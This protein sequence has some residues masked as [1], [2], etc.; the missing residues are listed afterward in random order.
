MARYWPLDPNITFLNHGAYGACPWPVL[1]AQS[2]WRARM[3]R[4]PVQFLG[5]ELETHLDAARARMAKLLNA[6]PDDLA[7]VPNATTGVNTVLRSLDLPP[8]DE[9]LS[10]HHDYNACLNVI[11]NR[12]KET[13]ANCAVALPP[14]PISS[15]DEAVEAILAKV[16]PRTRLAVISHVTSPTALVMPIKQ[17]IDELAARG[18]DTL[19]DGAHAAMVPTDLTA[20]GAAYY[21]GNFHKWLCAPKGSGF[22]HVR[23]DRQESI[24][25]LVISHGANSPRSDRSAFRIEFD[26]TGTAD[27]TAYL[28]TPAVLD[29]FDNVMAGGWWAVTKANHDKVLAARRLL[30]GAFPPQHE[31]APEAMIGTM[32][33]IELPMN[34]PPASSDAP[35]D[36]SPDATFPLDPLHDYLL[37][38]HSIEVPVFSW[39]HTP[40]S[41]ASRRRLMRISAHL[42]NDPAQ[43]EYLASVL[44]SLRSG[45]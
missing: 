33:A 20:L 23:R 25:P 30:L 26:W 14:F 2:E 43:Y 17:I 39:P 19:V 1:H 7:F 12:A 15:P 3:E 5:T 21:T 36:V 44:T 37:E 41:G 27:P 16:T 40:A 34:L 29:F 45:G 9:V 42:Y 8:G 13:G 28:A 4:E 10:T 38:K 22:L 31:P 32:A 6:D 18:V 35:P 24:R 11:R